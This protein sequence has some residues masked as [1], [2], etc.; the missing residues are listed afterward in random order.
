[1]AKKRTAELELKT[2]KR[3]S[4]FLWVVGIAA[5]AILPYLPSLRGDFV[6]DDWYLILH[7]R[8]AHSLTYISDA[9]FKR[10]L[11][12]NFG[13]GVAYYRPLVTASFQAN[14][15]MAGPHPLLFRF[16]N[17]MLGVITAILVFVVGLRLTKS[18]IASGIAGI[19]FAVLPSHAESIAW[20]SGRTDILSTIFLLGSLL[21][22]SICYDDPAKFNWRAALLCSLLF[23][24]ALMSKENALVLPLL[25]VV[26]AW[27]SARSIT[28]N[29]VLRWAGVLLPPLV[30]YIVLRR[31]VTGVS[32]DTSLFYMLKERLL[33]VGIA[34]GAYPADDVRSSGNAR[35]L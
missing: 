20:V 4:L 5:A 25:V 32:L 16:T 29:E 19:C 11:P 13:P 23:L 35:G 12:E 21:I 7:P 3:S 28:R 17:L 10:F 6:L 15:M 31:H 18:V 30:V 33:G 1:M 34:Y 8:S 27:V 24:C 9:L 2:K 26:Y 14:Y 22:F